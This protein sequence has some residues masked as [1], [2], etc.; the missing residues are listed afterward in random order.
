MQVLWAHQEGTFWVWGL[1]TCSFNQRPGRWSQS[2][3]SERRGAPK[4]FLPRVCF[5]VCLI[6]VSSQ[7]TPAPTAEPCLWEPCSC[8]G[9]GLWTGH[10]KCQPPA[11]VCAPRAIGF[12]KEV[13]VS[14]GRA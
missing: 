11:G 13:E 4:Y 6:R 1:G 2:R 3:R 5:I 12:Q 7:L 9:M 8:S 10:R 14:R